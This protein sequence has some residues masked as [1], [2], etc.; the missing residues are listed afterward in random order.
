MKILNITQEAS[1]FFPYYHAS[2]RTDAWG[3]QG[4][5]KH[6]LPVFEVKVDFLPK[7]LEALVLTSDLQGVIP[8]DQGETLL[9]MVLPE[10]LAAFLQTDL[11]LNPQKTGVIL[12]GDFYATLQSRGGLDDVRPVWRAF[13][14]HFQWVCGVGGNHDDFGQNLDALQQ[15]RREEGIFYLENEEVELSGLSIGGISGV[16]GSN[17]KHLRVP[18][19]D[20]AAMLK[21][22]L[23]RRPDLMVMHQNPFHASTPHKGGQFVTDALSRAPGQ[24]LVCGHA[25]WDE[26]LIELPNEAQVLN[27]GERVFVMTAI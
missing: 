21:K 27:T 5:M 10:F 18:E 9:G 16:A 25:I 8:D 22:R 4:V 23:D 12:P 6:D 20:M 1:T 17:G 7:Y 14:Q 19:P 3:N 15:F 24:L 2:P 26:P 13:R 11:G